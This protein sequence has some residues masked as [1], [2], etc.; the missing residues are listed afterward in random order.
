MALLSRRPTADIHSLIAQFYEDIQNTSKAQEHAM[1][2][3]KIAPSRYGEKG[4]ALIEKMQQLHF[5]CLR[6]YRNSASAN[7]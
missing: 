7:P 6:V 4:R 1:E 2:A 5:G 3:I